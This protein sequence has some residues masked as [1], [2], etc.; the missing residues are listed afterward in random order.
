MVRAGSPVGP[1]TVA[2]SVPK[3]IYSIPP[4]C[5][6]HYATYA[7]I[8]GSTPDSVYV[9]Y[10]PGYTGVYVAP[11]GVVVYGTGYTYP[12]VV[13]GSWWVPCPVTYG[14]GWG[15][16][17]NPFTGFAYGF[18]AGAAFDC[19]C[20]PYWG[21]Y[22]WAHG[23]GL[24]YSHV[25]LNSASFYAHWGTAVRGTGSWGYNAYTGREW[26]AQRAAVFNPYTGAYVAGERGTVTNPYGASVSASRGVTGNVRTGNAVAWNNSNVYADHNGNVYRASSTGGWD[27]YNGNSGWQTASAANSAWANRQSYAQTQ[28]YQ[29]YDNY[30]S[31]GG[32][33]WGGRSDRY[34]R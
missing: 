15:M 32:G 18:A 16:A 3:A 1:W 2:T 27:R 14:F 24:S 19:W 28:G 17:V 31:Y 25:N 13:A 6:V 11:G 4:S 33:G 20:H 30:R 10:T 23:Y 29:R 22:G 5:P 21:C 8:Y 34:R 9:G 12:A 7:Y 26:S